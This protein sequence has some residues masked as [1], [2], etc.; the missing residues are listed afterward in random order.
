MT[1]R[2]AK[3]S[4]NVSIAFIDKGCGMET[5]VQERISGPFFSTKASGTG[6]GL[7]LCKKY[8]EAHNGSIEVKSETGL[9]STFTVSL[10]RSPST[11]PTLKL[12]SPA[13]T[14]LRR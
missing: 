7:F 6:L 10:P 3:S 8:V 2:V 14:R 11:N 9:G 1:I 12:L 4:N 13:A 5:A